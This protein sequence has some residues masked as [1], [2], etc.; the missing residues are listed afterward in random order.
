MWYRSKEFAE[1]AELIKSPFQTNMVTAIG[2]GT[3]CSVGLPLSFYIIYNIIVQNKEMNTKPRNI[4]L[5]FRVIS[6]SL[7]LI[8]A[9]IDIINFKFD[10]KENANFCRFYVLLIS[11]PRILFFLNLLLSLA[12]RY[13]AFN[14]SKW[15]RKTV[16]VRFVV[17]F[18]LSSNLFFSMG[19]NW[20]HMGRYAQLQCAY[21]KGKTIASLGTLIF[22]FLSCII[23]QTIL[24]FK[25]KKMFC[26][27]RSISNATP[28]TKA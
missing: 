15:H 3:C 27:E 19:V 7:T 1:K 20:V 8:E 10:F 25:T 13:A 24:Y 21:Q 16:T 18:L 14:H 23:L 22:V 6:G 28:T 4:L 17:I 5:L 26:H 2:Y 9:F 11:L 12:D